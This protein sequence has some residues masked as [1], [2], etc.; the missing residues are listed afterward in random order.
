M[1]QDFN[2]PVRGGNFAGHDVHIHN[3]GGGRSPKESESAMQKEFYDN[4]GMDCPRLAREFFEFLMREY[5]L[6]A[7]RIRRAW[8]AGSLSWDYNKH[9]PVIRL[10]KFEAWYSVA[11][12]SLI[13]LFCACGVLVT[14]VKNDNWIIGA[15]IYI[16]LFGLAIAILDYK[17][18][19][20]RATARKVQAILLKR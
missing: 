14:V 4:T 17:Y 8:G 1:T 3:H 2:G 6:T 15:L 7:R 13:F 20:P 18:W 16:A 5:G 12:L 11:L 19:Q 9:I 10:P